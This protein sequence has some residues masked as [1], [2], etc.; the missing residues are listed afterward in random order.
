MKTR[1]TLLAK[2]PHSTLPSKPASSAIVR[3]FT[4]NSGVTT[5]KLRESVPNL[6]HVNRAEA[7]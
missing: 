2:F 6:G 3:A 7:G 1:T 4:A 5:P